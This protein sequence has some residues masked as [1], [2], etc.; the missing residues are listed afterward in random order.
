MLVKIVSDAKIIS[1]CSQ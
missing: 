1:R